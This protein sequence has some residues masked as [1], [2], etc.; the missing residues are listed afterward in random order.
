MVKLSKAEEL[1]VDIRFL[2]S[3]ERTLLAWIRTGL[4][5]QAGGIALAAFSKFTPIPGI[6]VLLLGVIVALIGYQRYKVADDSIRKGEL[7][8]SGA[9]AAMQVY[10]LAILA[11]GVA[12]LQVTFFS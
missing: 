9:A 11:V 4:T 10:A 2:L 8:P 1:D 7:P 5:I 12:L 6:C 3:N